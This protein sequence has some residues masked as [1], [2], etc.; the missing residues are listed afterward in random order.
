V[1]TQ[2]E[3]PE[4]AAYLTY[5]QVEHLYGLSRTSAWRAI[6]DG[7]L[8]ASKIGRSLRINRASLDRF[9]EE[10]TITT[11]NGRPSGMRF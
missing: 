3:Q 11:G 6:R 4:K 7:H 9:M 5:A 2:E 8:Q 10:H 1:N